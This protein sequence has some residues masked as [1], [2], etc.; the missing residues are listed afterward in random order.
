MSTTSP[1]RFSL[2]ETVS[3]S[4]EVQV[5]DPHGLL[6]RYL[7]PKVAMV[8][9][10]VAAGVGTVLTSV[11]GGSMGWIG[12]AFGYVFLMATAT[13]F[14]GL[15]WRLFV[16]Q[17]AT[18]LIGDVAKPYE[19]RQVAIFRRIQQVT[20]IAAALGL[21]GLVPA[22]LAA[23]NGTEALAVGL[24]IAA[25]AAWVTGAHLP[26]PAASRD[27]IALASVATLLVAQAMAQVWHDM[28]G[29]WGLLLLRILHLWGFGAWFG[30]AV[31]NVGIAVRAAREDLRIPVVLA[32]NAQL[33]RFRWIV[34]VTL[35]TMLVTGV[36][37]AV[38]FL[39]VNPAALT[40]TPFGELVLVKLG[41]IAALV[42][43]FISCPMWHACS[44]IAGMCDISDLTMTSERST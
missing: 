22:Y 37:Q 39:G 38:I 23:G 5:A 44:P 12:A 13:A 11:V 32:A 3:A 16:V 14:G 17:P 42:G 19:A 15:I 26:L 29:S 1:S 31:W 10:A 8:V 41:L 20:W 6:N 35:P 34:R 28:P 7:L 2:L 9:I 4:T 18:A 30:G 43:I 36:W 33:E 27:R 24:L 25:Y 40:T 21:A